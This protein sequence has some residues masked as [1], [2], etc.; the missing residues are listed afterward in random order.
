M[1]VS[2]SPPISY[3]ATYMLIL[4]PPAAF[5]TATALVASGNTGPAESLGWDLDKPDGDWVREEV[6][7]HAQT[8]TWLELGPQHKTL[9]VP[10]SWLGVKIPHSPGSC[11]PNIHWKS[12]L[13]SCFLLRKWPA[14]KDPSGAA[15]REPAR[16]QSGMVF[17]KCL[18]RIRNFGL[19]PLG[20]KKGRSVL[21]RRWGRR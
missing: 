5:S 7:A 15:A 21:V 9:F 10:G 3:S 11:A 2:A 13:A 1:S 8:L 19:Q 18:T 16:C 6:G 12:N 14:C 17:K 4:T 20:P